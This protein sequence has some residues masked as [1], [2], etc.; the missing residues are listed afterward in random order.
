MI[1]I[2]GSMGEGGGQVLRTALS[3]SMI[4]GEA[5]NVANIRAG[6]RKPGLMRQHLTAVKAAEEISGARVDGDFPGSLE[7]EFKPGRIRHG[8]YHFAVGTA[9]SATLVLQTILPALLSAE[10]ES[11][12]IMEGGTHNPLAPPFDYLDKTFLPLL[13]RMGADVSV[14][15]FRHGFFPAGGGK[16][17]VKAAGGRLSAPSFPDRGAVTAV[18]AECLY[19]NLPTS[20]VKRECSV[21]ENRLGL[22]RGGARFRRVDS[23]GPGNAAMVEVDVEDGRGGVLTEVFTGFGERQITSEM[24][25]ERVAA[26]AEEYVNADAALGKHTA[27]Q[28]LLPMALAGDGEFSTLEPSL[29]ATTNMEVIEK[30][31]PVSFSVRNGTGRGTFLVTCK[32][33]EK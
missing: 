2:D 7:L 6:R 20:I 9:G 28:I 16:F 5:V 24:V 10:G 23:A 18:R 17:A 29:H 21:L 1:G 33:K 15:L 30:F 14:V 27:D 12:L 22:E 3:L 26:E 4:T 31:L 32:N 8:S 11:D 19:A 25:A 13:R